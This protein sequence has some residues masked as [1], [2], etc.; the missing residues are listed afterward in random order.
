MKLELN[1]QTLETYINEAINEELDEILGLSRSEINN[2]WG[3]EWDPNL[4]RKQNV[5]NR[6]VQKALIKQ[7]GYR[8]HDEYQAGEGHAIN[9]NPEPQ[10]QQQQQAQVPSE[11]PY[12]SDKQKTGQFQTWFNQNMGG[13]LVVDGIWGPK[14][15]A[16]YQQWLNSVSN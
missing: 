8:N 13:K 12:K 6:R 4:S 2:K 7:R 14:T 15:E 5:R 3:Y 9:Q 10:E 11:Y 16:A 1:E